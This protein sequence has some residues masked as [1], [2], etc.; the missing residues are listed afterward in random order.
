[1]TVI[2]GRREEKEEEEEEG[3]AKEEE[4]E[5][6]A[7]EEDEEDFAPMDTHSTIVSWTGQ[8]PVQQMKP[9][10]D[11]AAAAKCTE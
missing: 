6:E 2:S 9:R 5:E 8:R 11:A 10:S 7:E 1:M 4:E 3:E